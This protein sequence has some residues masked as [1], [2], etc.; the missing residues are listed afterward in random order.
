M[1]QGQEENYKKRL[2]RKRRGAATEEQEG[3]NAYVIF[4]NNSFL[5]KNYYTSFY[6]LS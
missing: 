6:S 5:K 4:S 2:E 1:I 3:E